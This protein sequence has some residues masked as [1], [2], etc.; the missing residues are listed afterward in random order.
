MW[1]LDNNGE[2]GAPCGV[3][4]LSSRLR[5]VRCVRPRRARRHST[6]CA[7]TRPTTRPRDKLCRTASKTE[8]SAISWLCHVTPS[9]TLGPWAGSVD[10]S[11]ISR[12]TR[13]EAASGSLFCPTLILKPGSLGST[14]VTRLRRD[15]EP[16]RLRGWP[17]LSLAGIRLRSRPHRQRFLVLRARSSSKHA[18]ATPPV[19]VHARL[20]VGQIGQ[21]TQRVPRQ[22]FDEDRCRWHRPATGPTPRRG[23]PV[24]R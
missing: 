3:P 2:S 23:R 18:V 20:L 5:V 6:D 17:G 19:R 8:N 14:R 24:P 11:S 21:R 16:L 1:R 10:S 7:S 22:R 15:Y 9:E 13:P 4:R 12:S